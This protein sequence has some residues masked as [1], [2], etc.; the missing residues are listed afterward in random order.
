MRIHTCISFIF[1][2]SSAIPSISCNSKS[3]VSDTLGESTVLRNT[4]DIINIRRIIIEMIS[5]KA[6]NK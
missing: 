2:A 4:I 3:K 6:T 1:K 5:V